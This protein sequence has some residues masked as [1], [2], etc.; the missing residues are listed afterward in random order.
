MRLYLFGRNFSYSRAVGINCR[1]N[2]TSQLLIRQ[3]DLILLKLRAKS[4]ISD[5]G[6]R[7]LV[8]R[9]LSLALA[10]KKIDLLQLKR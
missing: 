7:R 10:R 2:A 5:N 4:L 1:S 9:M 6:V 3:E 8:H